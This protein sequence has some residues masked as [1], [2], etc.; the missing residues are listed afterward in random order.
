MKARPVKKETYIR[1]VAAAG[2]REGFNESMTR[3]FDVLIY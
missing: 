3:G 2:Y 1:G